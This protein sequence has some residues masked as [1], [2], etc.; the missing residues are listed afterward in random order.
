MRQTGCCVSRASHEV[1][2][3]ALRVAFSCGGTSI[4]LEEI[5]VGRNPERWS[6]V[7]FVSECRAESSVERDVLLK[8]R[9]TSSHPGQSPYV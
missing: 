3:C 8:D 2:D 9:L 1:G 4:T 6:D 5:H 7:K